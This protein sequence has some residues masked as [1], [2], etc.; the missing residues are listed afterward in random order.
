GYITENFQ[1]A[2]AELHL[3]R[4]DIHRLA[5]NSFQASFVSPEEKRG[6]IQ[7]LDEFIGRRR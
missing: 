2:H 7:E 3:S 4:D 6:F 1:A 5:R